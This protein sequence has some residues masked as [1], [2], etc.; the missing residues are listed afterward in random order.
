MR[1]CDVVSLH[2]AST[3]RTYH[4]LGAEDFATMENGAAFINTARGA[5]CGQ[6]ALIAELQRDRINAIM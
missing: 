1:T 2:S 5:I 6:D 4:M 3:P